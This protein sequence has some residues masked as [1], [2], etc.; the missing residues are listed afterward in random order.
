[1]NY[2]IACSARVSKNTKY[3]HPQLIVYLNIWSIQTTKHSD[4]VVLLKLC[5]ILD[6]WRV[7][8]G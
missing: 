8:D 3:F 7:M 5:G 2:V 6:H 4:G 1:M